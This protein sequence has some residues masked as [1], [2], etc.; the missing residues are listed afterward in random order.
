MNGPSD[1]SLTARYTAATWEWLGLPHAARFTDWRGRALFR[2]SL[3]AGK[4]LPRRLGYAHL[5]GGIVPR[6]T[7]MDAWVR[8][9]GFEQ[10]V[11]IAAGYSPRGL[12]FAG[13]G[14][15][16]VEVD[17]PHV[18]AEKARLSAGVDKRPTFLG[19]DATAPDFVDRVAAACAPGLKTAILNEG[20]S[21]Y[22]TRESYVG[23][24]RNF[25]ALA[26]RLDAPLLTDF[27]RDVRS[28]NSAAALFMSLGKRAVWAIADHVHTYAKSEAD[29]R[30]VFE[31][32]GWR[33]LDVHKPA[34]DPAYTGGHKAFVTDWTYLVEAVPAGL[35]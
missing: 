9:H 32:A 29:V 23:V 31:E 1:I 21:M 8:R 30:A 17:R 26:E 12:M 16:Y 4:V 5:D 15:R 28:T 13:E 14:V 18:M 25:R 3:V 33:I 27:I 24:L 20:M 6:H 2:A 19:V 7:F 10:I 35:P 22:F 11:E 34:A